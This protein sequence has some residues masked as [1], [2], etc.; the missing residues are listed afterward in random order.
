MKILFYTM[1]MIKGGTERTISNLSNELIK[2]Y[3]I[4][5]ITN[6]NG[7][8]EYNL[9]K[10]IKVIPIDKKDKRKEKI[11]PKIITKTS[12]YRTKQLKEIIK[13]EKPNLIIATLPEPTIRILSLKKVF[14]HIPIIV[15]IRN[16]P[17]SEFK[18][19]LKTIRNHYYQYADKI[20]IQDIHYKKYFQKSIFKKIE[21]IPNYLSD[22][23]IE[24]NKKNEK[25]EKTIL[26]IGRLEKQKNIPL[27]IKSFSKLNKK[28]N[29]YKLIIIGE[30]REKNKVL[31]LIKEKK[32]EKRVILKKTKN[33]IKQELEKATLFVLPS[34]YEGMPNVLL[35]AMASSLPVITTNST[36]AL[37]SIINNNVNGIIIEKNH[38]QELTNK[39]EFLLE[40]KEK[41]ERLSKEAV[42][43]RKKY[44]KKIILKKWNSIIKETT[45]EGN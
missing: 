34:N 6:I 5:I 36:E 2:N 19:I 14:P 44:S 15:S 21:V 25:V 31:K 9:N 35:E 16:H 33:H 10:K 12:S 30:G 17:N 29:K 43:I 13:Q 18:G 41:R 11:I 45:K 3:D 4:T 38:Q 1:A 22:E 20:V 8:I 23:F 27:L 40:N 26:T 32:L 39:I 28:F 42:K 24:N 7:P 37:Y